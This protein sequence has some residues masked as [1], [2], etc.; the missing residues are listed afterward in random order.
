MEAT[1]K[2]DISTPAGRKIVKE[3]EKHKKLVKI[4]YPLPVG[5]DGITEETFSVDEVFAELDKKLKNHYG[6]DE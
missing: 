5:E 2:I 3:L 6:V 4:T 1:A